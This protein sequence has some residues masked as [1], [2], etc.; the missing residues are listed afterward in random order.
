[1]KNF[2]DVNYL[3]TD[4]KRDN[5]IKMNLTDTFRTP[6]RAVKRAGMTFFAVAALTAAQNVLSQDIRGTVRDI[7]TNEPLSGVTVD[8]KQ[9]ADTTWQKSIITG[10]DGIYETVAPTD[11]TVGIG[12]HTALAPVWINYVGNEIEVRIADPA[13]RDVAGA[14]LYGM[15]ARVVDVIQKE[16]EGM[17][18]VF[19]INRDRLGD[20]PLAFQ[21][22]QYGAL[23]TRDGYRFNTDVDVIVNGPTAGTSRNGMLKSATA[24]ED[25]IFSINHEGYEPYEEVHGVDMEGTTD[26]THYLMKLVPTFTYNFSG[27][28]IPGGD[29]LLITA[30]GLQGTDTVFYDLASPD[31]AAI[32]ESEDNI[33]DFRAYA[34]NDSMLLDTTFTKTAGTYDN[35]EFLMKEKQ[36][37]DSMNYE[38]ILSFDPLGSQVI[39]YI[40]NDPLDFADNDTIFHGMATEL[41]YVLNYMSMD[42]TEV[43][44]TEMSHE[45]YPDRSWSRTIQPPVA[46]FVFNL[47]E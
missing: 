22:G 1:M 44:V 15:D 42:S 24:L 45:D 12:N 8:I 47:D 46:S 2:T 7:E 43:L 5:K 39:S 3:K 27:Q 36:N 19:R 9:K 35:L 16:D 21:A 30:T 41:D 34:E 38:L 29:A 14:Q 18:S 13:L 40:R 11:T 31:F 20:N 26:I 4:I 17:Y 6:T 28:L 37:Q 32:F 23:F 25:Y 10:E 33:M